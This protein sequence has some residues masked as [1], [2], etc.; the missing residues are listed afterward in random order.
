[1]ERVEQN[2]TRGSLGSHI[3][4][5]F[6]IIIVNYP[7]KHGDFFPWWLIFLGKEL[8][9][10]NKKHDLKYSGIMSLLL[11]FPVEILLFWKLAHLN[12]QNFETEE[13]VQIP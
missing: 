2:L 9:G 6:L 3:R 4:K 11:C 5:H 8:K 7:H 13:E 1:M 10:L 12:M